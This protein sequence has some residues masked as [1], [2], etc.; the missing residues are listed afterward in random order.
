MF[1]FLTILF[2]SFHIVLAIL[3]AIA[4]FVFWIYEF[5]SL[6]RR[7]DDQFPGR[8]DK[9]LWVAAFIFANIAAAI[10]YWWWSLPEGPVG[11]NRT[12]MGPKSDSGD[13]QAGA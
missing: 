3:L 1:D 5:V 12:W 6:M 9:P 4:A 10:A 13:E 8:Y 2:G 7:R 11:R